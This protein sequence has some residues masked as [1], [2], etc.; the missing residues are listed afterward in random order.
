M[1]T[2]LSES[3][4]PQIY[5]GTQN[6]QKLGAKKNKKIKKYPDK[7]PKPPINPRNHIKKSLHSGDKKTTNFSC[8]LKKNQRKKNKKKIKK[9]KKSKFKPTTGNPN[10]YTH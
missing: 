9:K 8:G 7:P 5:G 6:F 3:K 1:F 10:I 4:K 2:P